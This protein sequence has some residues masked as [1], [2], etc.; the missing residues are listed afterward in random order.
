MKV[1]VT[2]FIFSFEF[3][4]VHKFSCFL[5]PLFILVCG[6]LKKSEQDVCVRHTV[7]MLQA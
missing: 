6:V 5:K 1:V 3:K 2:M 4:L 7:Q